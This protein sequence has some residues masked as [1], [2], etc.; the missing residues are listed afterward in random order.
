MRVRRSSSTRAGA[1]LSA[2]VVLITWAGVRPASAASLSVLWEREYSAGHDFQYGESVAASPDGATVYVTGISAGIGGGAT[3]YDAFITIAYDAATG[4]T[5]WSDAFSF[6]HIDNWA[7]SVAVS[8]DGRYVFVGG[9][10]PQA[11]A[12]VAYDAA[13][14]RRLW[15]RSLPTTYYIGCACHVVVSPDSRSVFFSVRR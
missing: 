7:T 6:D 15:V 11:H 2:L 10:T 5:R 13:T 9:D 3:P 4:A 8:P 14:G 1:V 12:L